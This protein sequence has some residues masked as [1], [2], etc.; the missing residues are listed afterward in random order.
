MSSPQTALHQGPVSRAVEIFIR[1]VLMSIGAVS[2]FLIVKPFIPFIA[3]AI[4][5]SIA[6]VPAYELLKKVLG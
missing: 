6:T 2:C 4:I 1:I 5:I 3:W